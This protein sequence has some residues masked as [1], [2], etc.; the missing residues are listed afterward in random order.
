[1]NP[2]M[3]MTLTERAQRFDREHAGSLRALAY[4]MLGSRAEA[5]DIVQEAWLRWANV[6]ES[7][8]QH[9][10]AFLSRLVTNLCLD[11]LGSAANRRE[12][13]FG[14][15]LPEPVLDD[16]VDW[17]PDPQSQAEFAQDVSVAFML[18][19]ERLSPLERAAFLLY[20]V[21]DLDFNE[22]ARRLDRSPAAVR[23]LASR[24]RSHVKAD[25]A[26]HEVEEEE[27]ERLF[28]AFSKAAQDCDVDALA[29]M[30]TADAVMLADGGGK[31]TAISRPLHGGAVIAKT[32]IGFCKLPTSRSWRLQPARVNGMPGCLVIDQATGE[33]I[34]TIALAPSAKEPGRI[35]AIY[36]QR[37]PDKLRGLLDALTRGQSR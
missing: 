8:V 1:M 29:K 16:E 28:N 18:A 13:Y 15:W 14:V 25:Y 27:R 7:T 31:A 2:A 23:Q 22:V 21:F 12:Q 35:G 5:E 36:I 30:L 19:L 6:D 4:R 34:Q 9:A 33:L 17:S 26:R 20:E 32:F 11:V 10:G 24:A 3:T 37:N